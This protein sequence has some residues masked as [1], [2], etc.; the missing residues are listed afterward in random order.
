MPIALLPDRAVLSVAGDDAPG[1]LQGL[2]TCNVETLPPGEARLG[3]LLTPQGKVLIDFL[4][5]R[6][7]EGFA[8]DVAR[9]LLP[10]L[11]RRL[12]LYRLRAKVAFAEAPLRVLAVWG[13][14]PAGAWLRD[15]RLPALGW[16]RHA[17]E[18][19]GPAPDATAEDYA[20]HRIGLGVPEGGADF[21]LG[22][23][24]PHEA[25]MDQLG[26]V[27]FRK[28]CY[29]GQEVVS[30]M[31]HRG[32][33]RTRVVPVAYAGARA[34]APGTAVTAGARA[35]GQTGGAAGARGLALLRLDR[36]AD[37]VAAGEAIEAGGLALRVERPAF[38][39]FEVPGAG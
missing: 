1:F 14:P 37:A 24:F 19:E 20:A 6:A 2:V 29:V 39:S 23:A 28:G 26:G 17:G 34:A 25:L 35:L 10:D 22:D 21:A 38:A 32:T 30:R 5:S 16:R 7:A 18:G 13:G 33:A 36:L 4:I 11:T 8:L 27:D 12:T 15:G 3:A 31:Q 9:A